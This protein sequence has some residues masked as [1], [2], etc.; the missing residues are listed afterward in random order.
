M[1]CIPP[2]HYAIVHNPVV[3]DEHGNVVVNDKGEDKLRHGDE[4]IRFNQDPFHLHFGE[5]CGPITPLP[6]IKE[7]QAIVLQ[8]KRDFEK[9]IEDHKAN[10]GKEKEEDSQ[11]RKAGEKWQLKGPLVYYPTVGVEI[12]KI[13]SAIVLGPN[14][15]LHLKATDDCNDWK[16]VPRKAGEEWIVRTVGAYLPEVY[17]EVVSELTGKVLNYKTGLHIRA[18]RTFT[19]EDGIKRKA[20]DE[21]LVTWEDTEVYFPGINEAIIQETPLKVLTHNQYC[22][23][24]NPY[25]PETR[26]LRLGATKLQKGPATFFLQP[27]ETISEVKTARIL[28]ANQGLWLTAKAGE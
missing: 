2:E 6:I 18:K 4:E 16:G 19:N 23:I 7:N 24:T 3:R 14:R 28:K 1:V 12:V 25:D 15:A 26:K 17:E 27:G 11:P 22:I 10:N 5:V 21:W 13:V 8:A 20:G 9:G